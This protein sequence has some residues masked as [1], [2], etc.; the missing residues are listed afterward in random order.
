[1]TNTSYE[2]RP[3]R[4]DLAPKG[5]LPYVE[6]YHPSSSPEPKIMGDSHFIIRHLIAEGISGDADQLAGLTAVQKA[7]SRAWQAYIEEILSPT[8]VYER[9]Y[10]D[11]NFATFVAEE[12]GVV[13]WLI[14][15]P[16]AWYV[17][18][19]AKN[20]LWAAGIGRHSMEEVRT[21]QEE[22]MKTLEARLGGRSYFHGDKKPS[23]ID[24]ILFGSLVSA[25]ATEANPSLKE[26]S[27]NSSILVAFVKRLT[28]SL[29]PEYEELLHVLETAEQKLASK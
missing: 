21:L 9:W 4:P 6:I 11:K 29:F 16:V 5:K 26:L 12:F 27:L 7:E 1:L 14:R 13:P 19:V 18:R 2:R 20:G 3:S 10:G 8:M 24:L 28:K 22:A 17:R 15:Q 23:E 25:V